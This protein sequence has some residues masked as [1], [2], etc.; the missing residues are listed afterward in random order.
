MDK[1]SETVLMLAAVF[2]SVKLTETVLMLAA[3]FA[4]VVPI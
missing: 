2:A 1:K 4:S 3:V